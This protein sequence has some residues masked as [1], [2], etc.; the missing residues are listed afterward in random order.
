MSLLN[1]GKFATQFINSPVG[2]KSIMFWAPFGNWFFVI[3]GIVERD[4]PAYKTSRN[5][6]CALCI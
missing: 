1:I 6:Q 2:P 4:R 3:N 5:M